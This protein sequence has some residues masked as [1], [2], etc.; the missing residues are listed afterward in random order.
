MSN[1]IEII[2]RHRHTIVLALSETEIGKVVIPN[3]LRLVGMETGEVLD[4][5]ADVPDLDEQIRLLQYANSVND[6]MPKFIR[7]DSWTDEAD[8]KT[9]DM[10]VMERLYPLPIHHFDLA[11]RA[12]MLATFEQKLKEL[13]SS[14]FIHGDFMRP[15]YFGNRGDDVWIFGN[16]LQTEQGLRLIDTGFSRTYAPKREREFFHIL[17][18]ER[19][20]IPEF[21]EYYLSYIF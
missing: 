13:H 19:H 1:N 15:T 18:R 9:H 11:T 10:I 8:G 12:L 4:L 6:L 16:I 20:E 5:G 2:E 7:K 21:A 3:T 17:I 14:N